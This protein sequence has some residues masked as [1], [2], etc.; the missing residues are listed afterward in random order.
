MKVSIV[1][2]KIYF[3]IVT[4]FPD[5]ARLPEIPFPETVSNQTQTIY[6]LIKIVTNVTLINT[7]F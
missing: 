2:E 4:D 5:Q 6:I 7:I 1:T 3:T